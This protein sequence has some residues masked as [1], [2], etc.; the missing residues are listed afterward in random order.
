[1]NR[2]VQIFGIILIGF[3]FPITQSQAQKHLEFGIEY[4]FSSYFGDLAPYETIPSA[5]LN[6][7][8]FGFYGG[9]GN[10]WGTIF[11]NY[12]T[13]EIFASDS[14]S[15][16][17]IRR[18]RNLDFRSPIT[19]F[20]TTVEINLLK[21]FKR[22]YS[23][24]RP[25]FITGLNIFK[26]NPQ[27]RYNGEWIDL[28]PLGTE[29]QGA[30]AGRDKYNLTQISIPFGAGLKYE[31]NKTVW[32]GFGMKI[33]MTFTDYLDDVSTTYANS[34]LLASINGQL[35]LDLS[36]RSDEID[37]TLPYPYELPRGNPKENDWYMTTYLSMGI[38]FQE[39]P[40]VPPKNKTKRH[41]TKC[42]IF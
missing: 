18:L 14:E 21:I 42:Y 25:L 12:T 33:R 10:S 15:P 2:S 4:G 23:A 40:T 34:E 8:S 17:E 29:G 3:L 24:V 22:K 35:A 37:G 31:L 39:D 6:T 28:Q 7:N 30:I 16:N 9:V 38:R 41:K 26:F 5:S 27:T 1:M 36:F 20:G 13:T 19:E 11:L 32:V